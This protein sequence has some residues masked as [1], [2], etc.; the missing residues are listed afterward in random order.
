MPIQSPRSRCEKIWKSSDGS[1]SCRTYDLHPRPAVG[2]DEEV[3][4]AER[5][6]RQDAAARD[7]LD[8]LGVQSLAGT[9]AV[10]A[11]E[12][13]HSVAADEQP[14]IGLDAEAGDGLEVGAALLDL[15]FL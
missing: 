6:H 4:L 3:G 5:A 2:Q 12:F 11:H 7:G 10:V 15:L 13:A 9:V 1:E 14:G 8:A